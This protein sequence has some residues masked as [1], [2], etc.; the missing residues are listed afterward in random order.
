M[1][2][3]YEGRRNIYALELV[4][5]GLVLSTSFHD[6]LMR[7]NMFPF[8]LKLVLNMRPGSYISLGINMENEQPL[9]SPDWVKIMA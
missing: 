6:L 8:L 1:R 7:I 4:F 2:W 9:E 3:R 5:L